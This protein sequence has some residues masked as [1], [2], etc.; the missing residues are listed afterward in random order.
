MVKI[1]SRLLV[2]QQLYSTR[3]K[4][5]IGDIDQY[6]VDRRRS[7]VRSVISSTEVEEEENK[8]SRS[9][10]GRGA[11]SHQHTK[12]RRRRRQPVISVIR[13][14]SLKKFEEGEY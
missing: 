2:N 3:V 11:Q 4:E 12:I 8:V 5:N 6:K 13:C 10:S 14:R 9:G 7:T 1:S